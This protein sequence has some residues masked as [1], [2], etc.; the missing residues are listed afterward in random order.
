MVDCPSTSQKTS[1]DVLKMKQLMGRTP[2]II[3]SKFLSVIGS[4]NE[5][6]NG[7]SSKVSR[8]YGNKS[9]KKNIEH[10]K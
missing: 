1:G 6:L 2:G 10:A 9:L 7:I 8:V 5:I 4:S 3:K